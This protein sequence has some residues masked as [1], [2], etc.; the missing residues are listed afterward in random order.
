MATKVETTLTPPEIDLVHS[1]SP[2]YRSKASRNGPRSRNGCWTCRT[3]KVKCDEVRPKCCRCIRLKLLCDYSP[4]MRRSTANRIVNESTRAIAKF[5]RDQPWS[6]SLPAHMSELANSASSIDLTSADHEAIRY[7]RTTFARLHHTKN[8]DYGLYA[9]IFNIAERE[10]IVMR[11][12]LAL[13]GQELEFRKRGSDQEL[14][15]TRTVTPLHHYAAALRMFAEAV[16]GSPGP[17]GRQLDLDAILAA[18]FLMLWYEKK[19]GDASCR[20]FANHLAG[21][22]RV[23]WH[24]CRNE[25]FKRALHE[26]QDQEKRLALVRMG[27]DAQDRE[28]ILSQFSARILVHLCIYDS[29]AAGH[30]LGG[31][32]VETLNQA[33]AF[34]NGTSLYQDR[35]DSLHRFSYGLYRVMWAQDYPQEE[36][37]DDLENRTVYCMAASIVQLRFM[38]SSLDNLDLEAAKTCFTEIQAVFKAT[39]VEFEEIFGIASDLAPN[40]DSPKRLVCNIRQLVPQYYGIKIQLARTLRRL[41]LPYKEPTEEFVGLIMTLSMQALRHRGDDAMVRVADALFMAAIETKDESR[42]D[43]F[44]ARFQALC[45]YGCNYSRAHR[46]LVRASATRSRNGRTGP[47]T[48]EEV[49]NAMVSDTG[50]V[51]RFVI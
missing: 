46:L 43:W 15:D 48:E 37:L 26:P 4:R 17:D 8:P 25:V 23:V 33:L 49:S 6:P 36:M 50:E 7:Y 42:R 45:A 22:A 44:I 38:I 5:A 47:L 14:A 39:D 30:G 3:K 34:T 20:G 16:D 24:R 10:P 13:G 21:A 18:I 32:L 29:V 27:D 1:P 19:F 11:V 12:V 2:E 41:G 28:R 51:E 35:S 9:I 31:H 40:F